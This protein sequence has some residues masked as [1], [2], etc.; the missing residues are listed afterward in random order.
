M[1]TIAC[2]VALFLAG[3]G[4][5]TAG[6]AATVGKLQA[7]N[8]KQAKDNMD[9]MKASIEASTKEMEARNKALDEAGKN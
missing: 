5:E 2:L 1:K 9:A 7:E 4:L 8:A 3:C 6:S